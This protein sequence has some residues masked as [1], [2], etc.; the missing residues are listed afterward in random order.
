MI[1]VVVVDD[2]ALV[3][4]GVVGLLR[5]AG[6]EVIG[7][8]SDGEEALRLVRKLKPDVLLL[9]LSMPGGMGGLEAARRLQAQGSTVPIVVLTVHE[10][11]VSARHALDAGVRGYVTKGNGAA[12]LLA[13][14]RKVA[15][16]GR[17]LTSAIAE[18]LAFSSPEEQRNPCADLTKRELEVVLAFA[19]G[20]DADT[21]A[22]RLHL[23][24]KTVHTY[25]YRA[26]DKLG[27]RNLVELARLLERQGLLGDVAP[28]INPASPST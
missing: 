2:H 15:A 8:G 18:A 12:E 26:T 22:A 9:D 13:A 10:D 24:R 21:I 23:S 19:R 25:K 28:A 6:I 17:Y 7:E 16:G 4:A 20:D 11:A 3:R 27:V 1:K 14:L 5:D